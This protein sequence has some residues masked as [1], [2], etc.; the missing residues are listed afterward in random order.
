MPKHGDSKHAERVGD[1]S[2]DMPTDDACDRHT[3]SA[4]VMN[5]TSVMSFHEGKGLDETDKEAVNTYRTR[6]STHY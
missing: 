6:Q 1:G 2:A 3:T 4:T 5:A